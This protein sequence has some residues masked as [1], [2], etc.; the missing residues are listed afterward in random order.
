M[1]LRPRH[2]LLGAVA[3]LGATAA[4]AVYLAVLLSYSPRYDEDH[5]DHR[6]Y[7][8]RFAALRAWLDGQGAATRVSIDFADLNGGQWKTVCLFGG[9]T[10][11]LREIQALGAEIDD[12]DR[13][14]L[15]EA[16]RR[17]FRIGP[18]E[19]FELAIAYI[20]RENKARFIHM[21]SGIGPR[22]QHFEKCIDRP[23]TKIVVGP[24]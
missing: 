18:I 17:G 21:K 20:D 10:D 19:E 22:G 1:R 9:Y 16:G 4:A 12:R 23:E 11:P 15:T 14:R 2:L 24:D 3:C 13:A 7:A 8:E 5:P 6:R